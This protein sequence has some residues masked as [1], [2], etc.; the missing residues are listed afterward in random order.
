MSLQDYQIITKKKVNYNQSYIDYKKKKLIIKDIYLNNKLRMLI[1]SKFDP[2]EGQDGMYLG[3]VTD[4]VLG[5]CRNVSVSDYGY[6]SVNASD[7]IRS[8]RVTS[9][10]NVKLEK[11]EEDDTLIVY[12]L[13]K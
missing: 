8:L 13:L 9:D 6:Y 3:F 5:Q 1:M 11:E 12:K 7:I 4:N 2:I 10:T